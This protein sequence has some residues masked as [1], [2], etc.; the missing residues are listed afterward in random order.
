MGKETNREAC[1]WCFDNNLFVI[2]AYD[3]LTQPNQMKFDQV[4]MWIQ[5]HNLPLANMT[6][7]CGEKIG[8]S[9]GEVEEV[10]VDEDIEEDIGWGRRLRVKVRLDLKKPIARGRSITKGTKYWIPVL[11]EKLSHVN[12]TCGCIILVSSCMEKGSDSYIKSVWPLVESSSDDKNGGS[13]NLY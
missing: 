5:L 8:K 13:R 1:S 7:I 12:F 4:A 11:Y 10:D 6:R 2:D 3:G 9:L